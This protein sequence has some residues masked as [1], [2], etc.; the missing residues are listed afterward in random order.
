[1]YRV[2]EITKTRLLSLPESG[3]GYQIVMI[4]HLNNKKQKYVIINA[5]YAIP[6]HK[7]SKEILSKLN[8][9]YF[10]N[11]LNDIGEIELVKKTKI[12]KAAGLNKI[13]KNDS[14]GAK[15][16][17][18]EYTRNDEEFIRFSPFE[19]DFRIDR[20]N[21]KVL[22]GTFATT[23]LDGQKCINENID[24]IDRYALPSE[25]EIMYAFYIN[26]ISNTEIKRGVVQPDYGK[27]GGGEE[28]IFPS[29]TSD[30]T[31]GKIKKLR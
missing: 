3:V 17:E 13:S 22:P 27:K 29:G 16:A 4:T 8:N 28:V 30:N 23:L 14:L 21:N 20:N 5:T 11:T 12:L 10:N 24:I 6:Y 18:I 31:V 15:D 9:I 25:R 7:Y 26:P 1:M 2:D 19:D